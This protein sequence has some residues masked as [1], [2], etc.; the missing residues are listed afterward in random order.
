MSLSNT[1]HA[2]LY[3]S[4]GIMGALLW[5]STLFFDP[6]CKNCFD[7]FLSNNFFIRTW[8]YAAK[9]GLDCP[10]P[11]WAKSNSKWVGNNTTIRIFLKFFFL[12]TIFTKRVLVCD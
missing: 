8:S 6:T 4:W 9:I 11:A 7:C 2:M 10:E 12:K 5:K 3:N 1:L